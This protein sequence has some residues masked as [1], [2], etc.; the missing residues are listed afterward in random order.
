MYVLHVA[1]QG[2]KMFFEK[3]QLG[4]WVNISHEP[5]RLVACYEYFTDRFDSMNKIPAR[6]I[7]QEQLILT[8][9]FS[10]KVLK[11]M[12]DIA[13]IHEYNLT[14]ISKRYNWDR[15]TDAELLRWA[16]E[17]KHYDAFEKACKVFETEVTGVDL[18][19][20]KWF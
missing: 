17:S 12:N 2:L 4:T 14:G 7:N 8:N 6:P 19:N 5:V 18:D 11:L 13:K 10:N 9:K 20:L 1:R 15:F 3:I 16:L